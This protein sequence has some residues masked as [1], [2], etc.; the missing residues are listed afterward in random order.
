[1]K[2]LLGEHAEMHMFV[3]VI[4]KGRNL[5][6]FVTDGLVDTGLIQIRHDQLASELIR[7]G[8]SHNSPLRYTDKLDVGRVDFNKSL[9]ELKRRCENCRRNYAE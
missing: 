9:A 1:M 6:R 7:R 8:G 3:G 5:G 2:H 4:S